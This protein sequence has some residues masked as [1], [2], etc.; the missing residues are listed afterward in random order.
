MI[1]EKI[2]FEQLRDALMGLKEPKATQVIFDLT[3]LGNCQK[4]EDSDRITAEHL[5]HTISN[6][7]NLIEPHLNLRAAKQLRTLAQKYQ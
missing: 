7:L 1:F 3:V 6:D 2:P 4:L 5:I